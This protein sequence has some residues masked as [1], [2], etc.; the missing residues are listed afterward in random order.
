MYR[1]I[2]VGKLSPVSPVGIMSES[3]SCPVGKSD[4]GKLSSHPIL[5]A[6]STCKVWLQ[7][8]LQQPQG[9]PLAMYRCVYTC[10]ASLVILLSD[11]IS[12]EEFLSP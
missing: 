3:V 12:M 10:D 2:A 11:A 6:I 9:F 4:V 1:L 5:S 8:C 7:K